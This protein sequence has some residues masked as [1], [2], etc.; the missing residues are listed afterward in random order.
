MESTGEKQREPIEIQETDRSVML[1]IQ[2]ELG[3]YFVDS[4][5]STSPI[6]FSLYL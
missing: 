3:N 4:P 6:Q 1:F 5:L 2:T